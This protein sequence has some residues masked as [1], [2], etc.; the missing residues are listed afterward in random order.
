MDST[1]ENLQQKTEEKTNAG[2]VSLSDWLARNAKKYNAE[3]LITRLLG[4]MQM[5]GSVHGADGHIWIESSDND[6]NL[7]EV[8]QQGGI[9]LN[10]KIYGGVLEA[11]DTI[12]E[13]LRLCGKRPLAEWY[14][15]DTLFMGK[16]GIGGSRI[17]KTQKG[18]GGLV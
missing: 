2:V 15:P 12:D 16:I 14:D 3:Y 5:G 11:L 4:L 18:K 17:D 6:W 13:A 8:L 7:N 10:N 1:Q 9:L